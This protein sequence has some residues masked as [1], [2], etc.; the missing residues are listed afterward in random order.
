MS[1]FV[2]LLINVHIITIIHIYRMMLWV[3]CNIYAYVS[4][5]ACFTEELML[6]PARQ[7]RYWIWQVLYNT[8]S[9]HTHTHTYK[10]STTTLYDAML[11]ILL[12]YEEKLY[13][14]N[15]VFASSN[16]LVNTLNC[17]NHGLNPMH[18]Y[19]KTLL[20]LWNRLLRFW[21]D[22]S[23][24]CVLSC[25]YLYVYTV[26]NMFYGQLCLINVLLLSF[27]LSVK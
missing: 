19:W 2:D 3:L 24:I 16:V 23:V 11:T 13:M 10:I 5:Q 17:V 12:F 1:M 20:Y 7:G 8:I 14:V 4:L 15:R 6:P 21:N 25:C 27:V 26:Y 9:S 18:R 22:M